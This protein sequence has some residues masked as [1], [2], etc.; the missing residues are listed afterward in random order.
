MNP[1]SGFDPQSQQSLLELAEPGDALPD[2]QAQFRLGAQPPVAEL[3]GP[4]RA[5]FRLHRFEV[6]NWGTFHQRV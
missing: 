6:Y 5:G 3:D 1:P 2:A 4:E